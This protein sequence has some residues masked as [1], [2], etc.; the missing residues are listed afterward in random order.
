[1]LDTLLASTSPEHSNRRTNTEM[2]LESD[3]LQLVGTFWEWIKQD[4][5]TWARALGDLRVVISEYDLE[6]DDTFKFVLRFSA[7]SIIIAMLVDFPTFIVF[8]A[9]TMSISF[10]IVD[11]ILYYILIFLSAISAK[12]MAFITLAA[13]S[14][15]R[16]TILAL[17]SSVYF[18]IENLL[19]YIIFSN[20]KLLVLYLGDFGKVVDLAHEASFDIVMDFVMLGIGSVAVLVFMAIRLIAATRYV[21]HVGTVRAFVIVAGT[22][23]IGAVFQALPM[24]PFMEAFFKV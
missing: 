5:N 16:C 12:V 11:F 15:R 4:I 21:F 9:H 2:A 7:F 6:S 18:P 1:M 13:A 10:M 20:K 22:A 8:H 19:D 23:I 3:Y 14:M 24:R 17:F